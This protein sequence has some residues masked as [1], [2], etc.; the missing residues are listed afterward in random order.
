MSVREDMVAIGD[1][2]WR[3]ASQG[4]GLDG[5]SDTYCL[6]RLTCNLLEFLVTSVSADQPV[7]LVGETGVGKTA[8]VQYLSRFR[9]EEIQVC[10]DKRDMNGL[11]LSGWLASDS[12]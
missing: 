7:L 6:N 10:Q 5:F 2:T 4:P 1:L 12:T 8:T 3:V 9:L 11:I